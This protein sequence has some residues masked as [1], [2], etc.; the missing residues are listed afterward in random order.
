MYMLSVLR[1]LLFYCCCCVLQVPTSCPGVPAVLLQPALQWADKA[2]FNETLSQLAALFVKN[3]KV[4]SVLLIGWLLQYAAFCRMAVP[5]LLSPGRCA[6]IAAVSGTHHICSTTA[7]DT[8]ACLHPHLCHCVFSLQSYMEDAAQHVGADMAQ[9]ILSGGPNLAQLE[10][11][12]KALPVPCAACAAA[13]APAGHK[14][15]H[16]LHATVPGPD[17]GAGDSDVE[18]PRTG[19]EG[20]LPVA[21]AAV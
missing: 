15:H 20:V 8:S 16:D 21:V 13:A 3:F 9:R 2:D 10:N 12:P 6:N 14:E 11:G 17:E 1:V 7:S 18:S 4:R 19:A 5:G